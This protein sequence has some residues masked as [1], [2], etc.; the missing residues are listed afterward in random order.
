[1]LLEDS[2]S[3][4]FGNDDVLIRIFR[5]LLLLS[6]NEIIVNHAFSVFQQMS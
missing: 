5:A 6:N 4:T 1:M 2:F 3:L